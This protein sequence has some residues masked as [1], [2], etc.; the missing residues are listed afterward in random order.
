[1]ETVAEAYPLSRMDDCL[2]IFGSASVF[3]ILDC[4]SGYFQIPVSPEI[5]TKRVQNSYGA[6]RLTRIHFSPWNTPATFQ[7]EL[8][9]ILS[10]VRCQT[11][12]IY[13]DDFIVFSR[14]IS[15][16]IQHMDQLLT[17]LWN[18]GV[19]LNLKKCSLF[20]PN[21]NYPGHVITPGKLS[22]SNNNTAEFSGATF[23]RKTTQVRAFLGAAS[24]NRRFI[25]IFS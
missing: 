20:P 16:H 10:G 15:S 1:M 8:E 21:V 25:K 13:L 5:T 4:N 7:Q 3:T 2:H 14:D 23:P 22:V 17:L 24:V 11:C 19:S 9:R 6:F 18:P 12:L